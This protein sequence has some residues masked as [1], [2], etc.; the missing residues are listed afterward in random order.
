LCDCPSVWSSLPHAPTLS[1]YSATSLQGPWRRCEHGDL[2]DRP[3]EKT[4]K[5]QET[6]A[7]NRKNINQEKNEEHHL[8]QCRN[9]QSQGTAEM[10]DAADTEHSRAR[11]PQSTQA[12]VEQRSR[13]RHE[14]SGPRCHFRPPEQ[15][16]CILVPLEAAREAPPRPGAARDH[17][18]VMGEAYRSGRG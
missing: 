8:M 1:A 14:G 3:G 11:C 2:L 5:S 6:A 16:I 15:L 7:L 9:Q 12:D 18:E 17:L 10:A 13:E 4:E